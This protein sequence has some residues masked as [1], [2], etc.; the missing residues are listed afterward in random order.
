[1]T[2]YNAQNKIFYIKRIDI[3]ICFFLILITFCVYS[4]VKE[5]SFIDYDDD[6]YVTENSNVKKGLAKDSVIWAFKSTFVGNWHPLTWLS[7]MLDVQLFG[8][9]SGAHHLINLYLHILNTLL[10]FFVF[11]RMTGEV[12]KSCFVAALFAFHPLHVESVAWVSERKDLLSTFFWILIMW[13]Y[14]LYVKHSLRSMYLLSLL[15]FLLGLMSKPMLVTLPFVLLLLDYWPLRR[16]QFKYQ[17]GCIQKIPVT[18][19]LIRE[20]IPFFILTVA[21]C[22]ITFFAQKQ[23]GAI[24]SLD[25]FSL[26]ARIGN[27]IIS[28]MEYIGKMFWPA[29]LSVFYPHPGILPVWKIAG[30]CFL[31]ISLCFLTIKFSRKY[32]WL[33]VGWLWY[34]GTLVPV[35]GFVQVGTQAMADRYTYIPLIGLFIIIAWGFPVVLSKWRYKEITVVPIAVTVLSILAVATWFQVR[36]WKDSI[37]LFEHALEVTD[38]NYVVHNNLGFAL[39]KDG[40][41]TEA[42]ENYLA[43]LRINPDFEM[44]HLNIGVI[45]ADRGDNEGAIK[46]YKEALRINP[47]YIT[48]YINLGNARLRQGRIADAINQYSEA[49]RLDPDSEQ[50]YNGLG[51]VMIRTGSIEKAIVFFQKALKLK[52]DYKEA[53]NNLKNTLAAMKK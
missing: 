27:A 32:P 47:D 28:Y 37:T 14:I 25:V 8:M 23:G 50:A 6:K 30:A 43:A 16:F 4:Q 31:L 42:V 40:K 49:L 9:N 45:L 5:H 41:V 36:Y 53:Q 33:T 39:K 38:N 21:S 12:W 3:L 26:K 1:M 20:K 48:A 13:S 10:L 51:A 22:A 17:D 35:I 19:S 46:H 44:A 15:L 24:G 52:P 11:S 34:I 18:I 2:A 29:K 7:H